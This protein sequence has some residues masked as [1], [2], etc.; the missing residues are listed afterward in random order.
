M[1]VIIGCGSVG[2]STARLTAPKGKTLII[3][4][5]PKRVENLREQGFEGVVGDANKIEQLKNK[6]SDTDIFLILTPDMNANLTALKKLRE[7]LTSA[8]IAVR[9]SN[10]AS[11]KKMED[12]KAD[13]IIQM[14]NV[15]ASSVVRE[16]ENYETRK[17][18]DNLLRILKEARE[19]GVGI[20]VHNSPDPDALASALSLKKICEGHK[21]KTQIIYGGEIGRQENKAFVNLFEMELTK[22]GETDY[23]LPMI[24]NLEKIALID[25][26]KPGANNVL[27]KDVVPNIIIDHHPTDEPVRAD[28]YDVKNIGAT[29]TTM[30]KYLQQLEIN[31][32][33]KLATALLYGIRTDTKNFTRNTT[34]E[35]LGA[36]AFLSPLA[37]KELLSK[38]ETPPMSSDTMDVMGKAI[39]NREV[40]GSYLISCVENI[41]DRDTLPQA[42][43]FLL[44]LEGI[45][46]VVV[47]GIVRDQI[48][49]SA[50]TN[51]VRLNL[52]DVLAK[53]FGGSAVLPS[54]NG[55]AHPSAGGH[56][57]SAGA[58]IPLGLLG[59]TEEKEK[60]VVL[61]KSA[62]KK[63]FFEA[64]GFE[65]KKEE[66][67]EKKS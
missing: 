52:G 24:N 23:I 47:F 30:T 65:E 60:L 29:S 20:V 9:A 57:A 43:E 58:Q 61:A 50:R 8:Y 2:L 25:A 26:S 38:V 41:R 6:F 11:V 32:D 28:F 45:S 27:P 18:A 17:S 49:V 34:P 1:Y 5:D 16:I 63:Q 10:L 31:I 53:A 15:L 21:I 37:D 40:Y 62:V 4:N 7:M 12:V 56:S 55:I 19:T 44:S 14:P 48:I 36:V 64:V 13:Y 3:D 67:K 51:D 66:K 54:K 42:A 46:T 22:I 35:D 39:E 59:E 33:S